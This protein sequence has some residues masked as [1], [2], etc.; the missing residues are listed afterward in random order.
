MELFAGISNVHVLIAEI[1]LIGLIGNYITYM[2]AF[3]YNLSAYQM[4]GVSA[5]LMTLT[6]YLVDYITQLRFLQNILDD[7]KRVQ[8]LGIAVFGATNLFTSL[9]VLYKRYGW[10]TALG[11]SFGA[12]ALAG[13]AVATLDTIIH[14]LK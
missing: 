9:F 7:L 3:D 1:V 10:F 2:L 14:Q 11:I 12:P 5:L 6:K 8:I 4:L 13:F